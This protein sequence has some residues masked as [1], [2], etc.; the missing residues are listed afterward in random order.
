VVLTYN[1]PPDTDYI[2]ANVVEPSMIKLP[3]KFICTQGPKDN[4]IGDFWRMIW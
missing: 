3:N 2:N 1:V 4:T